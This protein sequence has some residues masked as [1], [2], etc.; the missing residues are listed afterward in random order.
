M[1]K[2]VCP[3]TPSRFN[4]ITQ[5]HPDWF[6]SRHCSYSYKVRS[7][8]SKFVSRH[9]QSAVFEVCERETAVVSSHK[10][11][12]S[13]MA[14]SVTR[15]RR[16]TRSRLRRA[17]VPV[18]VSPPPDRVFLLDSDSVGSAA[19]SDKSRQRKFG[20]IMGIVSSTW[21]TPDIDGISISDEQAKVLADAASHRY[22]PHLF[23]DG[24]DGYF[25]EDEADKAIES[26]VRG[27]HVNICTCTAHQKLVDSTLPIHHRED[28]QL[29]IRSSEPLTDDGGKLFGVS[30]IRLIMTYTGV[31]GH[32]QRVSVGSEWTVSFCLKQG[33]EVT[34]YCG[35]PDFIT[36]RETGVGA[37]FV[38]TGV[39]EAQSDLNDSALQGGIYA[40]GELRKRESGK[41]ITC[42]ALRKQKSASVLIAELDDSAA[43]HCPLSIGGVSYKYVDDTLSLC[44][45]DSYEVATFAKR[46]V[47]CLTSIE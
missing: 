19:A 21:S 43:S 29:L 47:A 7:S 31:P 2:P 18:V 46:L 15:E 16:A 39:G 20:Q 1:C 27:E 33:D 40:V 17:S 45:K 42:I 23:A 5:G 14:L 30:M 25:T 28:I 12:T 36:R 8:P 34:H 6:T 35:Y 38:I 4:N 37:T 26:L 22:Y 24:N 13:W 3:A 9:Q 11:E 32:L 44:L 41:K 10:R